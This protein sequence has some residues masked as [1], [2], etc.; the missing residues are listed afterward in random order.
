[1]AAGSRA[2]R[3][4]VRHQNRHSESSTAAPRTPPKGDAFGIDLDPHG[5]DRVVQLLVPRPTSPWLLV[6]SDDLP[7]GTEV[8]QD[9]SR[10]EHP[11]ML[12]SGHTSGVTLRTGDCANSHLVVDHL[13]DCSPGVDAIDGLAAA[14]A[15]Q[16]RYGVDASP[17][18][19]KKIPERRDR[20]PGY[21]VASSEPVSWGMACCRVKVCLPRECWSPPVTTPSA[22]NCVA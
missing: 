19:R 10:V 5:A 8:F 12:R 18:H 21:V 9:G 16:Q 11:L 14:L 6:L 22:R 13:D 3:P 17:A 15:G 4:I 2:N 7:P 1:M 20:H